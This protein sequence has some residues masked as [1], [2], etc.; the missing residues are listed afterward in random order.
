VERLLDPQLVGKPVIVGGTGGRGVVCSAS[1]EAR[2]FGV[3][4]AMP[5]AQAQ[6]LCPQAACVWSGPSAYHLYSRKVT[7][8]I[9]ARVPV[10]E[11]ASVDEFY[12]DLCGME[13]HFP[14]FDYLLELKKQINAEVG[15]PVSFA[16]ATNKL[17]SKIA[18]NEAKPDGQIEI[19]PGTEAAYLA[20]LPVGK[21]P[22]CGQKM[23]ALLHQKGISFIH[24]LVAAGP[25]LLELW[26]GKWGTDL[27]RKALGEDDSPIT[28]FHEQKSMSAENTFEEDTDD[29]AFLEMQITRLVEK[30]GFE[31]RQDHKWTGC[32]AIKIRYEN[33][34][35]ITR[36]HILEHTQSDSTL[37]R[38]AKDLFKQAYDNSRKVRLLGVRF[39]HLDDD[40][41]QMSLFD[42]QAEEKKLYAA[43]DSIKQQFGKSMVGRAGGLKGK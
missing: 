32:V 38:R 8:I 11:K 22:G 21:L 33:F 42:N 24:Q 25:A 18:T 20:P 16:L 30:L 14:V 13:K 3:Q 5:I 27:Y 43:I 34:E 4:S 6:K 19:L 17:I 31:L 35:T 12:L 29:V 10:V 39:S 37:I 9:L 41:L 23:V 28:P 7:E 26:L 36:Q 1:Y 2:K 15:L 40:V